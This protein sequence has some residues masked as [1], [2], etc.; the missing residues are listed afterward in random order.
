VEG[1]EVIY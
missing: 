1:A